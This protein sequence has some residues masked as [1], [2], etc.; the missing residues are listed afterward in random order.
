MTNCFKFVSI[1]PNVSIEKQ[2]KCT[3]GLIIT[4]LV[5]KFLVPSIPKWVTQPTEFWVYLTVANVRF[6]YRKKWKKSTQ[7]TSSPSAR[8]RKRSSRSAFLFF[9][10]KSSVSHYFHHPLAVNPLRFW[11]LKLSLH[12]FDLLFNIFV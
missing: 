2:L 11:S 12:S 10:L 7:K 5:P 4:T 1:C 3:A 9:E 8:K 6:F